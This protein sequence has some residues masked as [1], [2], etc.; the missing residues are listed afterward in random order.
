MNDPKSKLSK[1]DETRPEYDFSGGIRGKHY[2][3]FQ[4]G[5][6]ITIHKADGT[7]EERTYPPTG[8]ASSQPPA[9]SH[10]EQ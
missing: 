1:Q 2:A 3:A 8:S 9:Y 7:L 5:F 6:R 10:K 4:L